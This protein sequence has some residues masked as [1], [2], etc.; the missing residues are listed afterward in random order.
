MA[1][2]SQGTRLMTDRR[3]PTVKVRV[4]LQAEWCGR[5]GSLPRSDAIE[6]VILPEFGGKIASIFDRA[7]GREWLTQPI[8]GTVGGGA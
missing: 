1:V 7:A 3:T 4:V 6:V 2:R 8:R 5:R